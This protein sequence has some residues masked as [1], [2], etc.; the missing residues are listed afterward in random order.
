MRLRAAAFG[1]V[2]CLRQVT[3]PDR[4]KRRWTHLLRQSLNV[5]SDNDDSIARSRDSSLPQ[6][7]WS[8]RRRK[9][10]KISTVFRK[11]S[12]VYKVWKKFESRVRVRERKLKNP[13]SNS[14]SQLQLKTF[15]FFV[16]VEKGNLMVEIRGVEPLTFSMPLRRSTN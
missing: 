6:L 10:P 8:R 15:K 16:S 3:K 9:P 7:S 14:N 12:K 2:S 1:G 5:R 11:V 13:F 4:V